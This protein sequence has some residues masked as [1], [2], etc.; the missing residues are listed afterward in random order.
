MKLNSESCVKVKGV[1]IN[2]VYKLMIKNQVE[3]KNVR[4]EDYKTITFNVKSKNIKKV[5]AILNNPC[6][7]VSVEKSYGFFALLNFL[8]NRIGVIVAVFLFLGVSLAN[9]FFVSSIRIFGNSTVSSSQIY[10]ALEQAGARVGSN[11]SSLDLDY[12]EEYL[13][14]N[15]DEISL[16]SIVTKGNT[17]VV[18][19]KEKMLSYSVIDNQSVSCHKALY[20]GQI[21]SIEVVSGTALV[22]VGDTV[23]AGDNLVAGYYVSAN[24][25]KI[26]CNVNAKVKAKVWF[27]SSEF[28]YNEVTENVRTGKRVEESEYLLFNK[29]VDKNA[30]EVDFEQF[31]KEEKYQYVFQNNILPLVKKSVIY[32]ETT[33][34]IVTQNFEEKRDELLASCYEKAH[35]Q[36]PFDIEISRK[37]DVIEEIEGGFVVSAYYEVETYI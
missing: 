33:P 7:N 12:C 32:Y 21:T 16:I 34:V 13:M 22:K 24:G 25:E 1:N 10:H 20:D 5:F 19:I 30:V 11:I 9:N 17:L 6:Y 15:I 31:E 23:K 4:R 18:N 35:S 37:F 27:S 28:F 3:V 2:R 14:T 8:K 26:E 36:M 29:V